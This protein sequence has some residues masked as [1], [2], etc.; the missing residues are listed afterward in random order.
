MV[1]EEYDYLKNRKLKDFEEI[2]DGEESD[3]SKRFK[4]SS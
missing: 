1:K 2:E 3:N 4:K